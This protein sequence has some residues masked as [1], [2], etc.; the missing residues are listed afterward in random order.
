MV[1]EVEERAS[2]AR[3]ERPPDV[4]ARYDLVFDEPAT[5]ILSSLAA[6]SEDAARSGG[7]TDVATPSHSG[8]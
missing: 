3:R 8:N 2:V 1:V 6:L 5:E 7:A 4:G